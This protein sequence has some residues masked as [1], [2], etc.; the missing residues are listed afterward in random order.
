MFF[1]EF[2]YLGR[3][4]RFMI[5]GLLVVVAIVGVLLV[6]L[7][8]ES[9]SIN[10][11]LADSSAVQ[12]SHGP[13]EKAMGYAARERK[14]ELFE[15]DPNTADSTQLLRLGLS[16]RQVRTIY[17][18]RA[19]GGVFQKP[20][21]IAHIYGLTVRQYR[22]L[23]PFVRIS[24]DFLPA[25]TLVAQKQSS[26]ASAAT[27]THTD[28]ICH[29]YKLRQGETLALNTADTT[30]LQRVPGIGSYFSRQIVARRSA[31]GGFH[32]KEQ[33]R[34][35]DS[36]PVDALAYFTVD[37]TAIRQLDVNRLTLQQ[38]RRHPYINFYQARAITDYRRLYGE[39]K[40]LE[41]LRQ[42]KEFSANDIARL[43]PYLKF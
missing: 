16:P 17:N 33:L 12:R 43:A 4:D 3:F 41:T 6:K 31:L 11:A 9:G 24:P 25:S 1:R 5:C 8:G 2:S 27:T 20:E 42:L 13:H 29:S 26:P 34:E 40:A 36:F 14:T 35:I 38:L 39:I 21:D 23:E 30:A 22:T 28:S 19:A 32:D 10:A 7:S 37:K 15:F 18:Y